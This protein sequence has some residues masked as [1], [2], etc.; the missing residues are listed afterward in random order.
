MWD[1]I[2]TK[3]V[4]TQNPISFGG[5]MVE[6]A[7][8]IEVRLNFLGLMDLWVQI[9]L[10]WFEFL[11]GLMIFEFASMRKSRPSNFFLGHF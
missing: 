6:R 10:G 7:E 5:E 8:E 4:T 11:L 3:E 1:S 9:F 2:S